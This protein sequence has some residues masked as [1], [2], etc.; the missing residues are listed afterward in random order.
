MHHRTD[1][2]PIMQTTGGFRWVSFR[3]A[4]RHRLA[5]IFH[6]AARALHVYQ[7]FDVTFALVTELFVKVMVMELP[8]PEEVDSLGGLKQLTV[9]ST[10]PE[11]RLQ[12]SAH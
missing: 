7:S 11:S 8:L 5:H 3:I 1:V 2:G 6:Y 12:T 10:V 4:R 9:I